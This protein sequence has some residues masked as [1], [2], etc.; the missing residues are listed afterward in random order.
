MTKDET[1]IGRSEAC[2]LGLFGDAAIDRLHARVLRR[3]GRFVLSGVA[4]AGET[5]VNDRPMD[6]KA[7]PLRSGDRIR[8]GK[9]VVVFGERNKRE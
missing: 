8:V 7:V 3:E 4:G 9:S 5:F 2:D 6:G 1:T